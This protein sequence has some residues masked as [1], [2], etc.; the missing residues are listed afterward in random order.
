MIEQ[1]DRVKVDGRE[2]TVETKWGSGKHM[3][4]CLSD[5]RKVLDLHLLIAVGKA[6]LL[7]KPTAKETP[8]PTF[9]QRLRPDKLPPLPKE[10]DYEE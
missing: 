4:Y 1:G 6:D 8:R 5:G 10:E 9:S 3:T 2:A 7:P